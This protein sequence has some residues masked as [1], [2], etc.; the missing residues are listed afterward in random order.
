MLRHRRAVARVNAFESVHSQFNQG[1]DDFVAMVQ[2]RMREHRKPIGIVNEVNGLSRA[3]LCLRNPRWLAFFKP[4]LKGLIEVTAITRFDQRA[5]DMR[6]AGRVAIGN[7]HYVLAG[8]RDTQSIEFG[9]HFVDAI[10]AHFLIF[11]QLAKQ[12]CVFEVQEIAEQ[13]QLETSRELFRR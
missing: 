8:D 10:T 6:A 7:A 9:D 1:R 11:G 12:P 13:V 4:F 5:A 2:P 3:Q